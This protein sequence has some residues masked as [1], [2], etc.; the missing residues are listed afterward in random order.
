MET[1]SAK[2][3]PK[4]ITAVLSGMLALLVEGLDEAVLI[5]ARTYPVRSVA[6]PEDD[7]VLR[8]SRDGFVE[9]LSLIHI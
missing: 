7:R 3:V 2:E 5:D 9:T 1:D 6:E 4:L 8:G